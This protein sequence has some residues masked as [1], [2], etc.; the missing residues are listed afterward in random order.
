[1]PP[2]ATKDHGWNSIPALGERAVQRMFYLERSD[3]MPLP[4]IHT[5]V[6]SLFFMVLAMVSNI[7]I[8]HR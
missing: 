6:A 2:A 7:V 5:L 8:R 1:M 4:W 3:I